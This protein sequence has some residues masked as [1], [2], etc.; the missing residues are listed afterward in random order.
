MIYNDS[1]MQLL[2]MLIAVQ[3]FKQYLLESLC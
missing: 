3:L 1:N 2:I